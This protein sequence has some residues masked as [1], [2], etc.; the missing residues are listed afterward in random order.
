MTTEAEKLRVADAKETQH[1]TFDD[2]AATHDATIAQP[3]G[4]KA[5]S[6]LVLKRNLARNSN[7]TKAEKTRNFCTEN[8]RQKLRE[9]AHE[10]PAEIDPETVIEYLEER[11]ATSCATLP[12]GGETEEPNKPCPIC[13]GGHFW[14]SKDGGPWHCSRCNPP[15]NDG[16]TTSTLPGARKTANRKWL[17]ILPMIRAAAQSAGLTPEHLWRALSDADIADLEAG[18]ID[19]IALNGFAKAIAEYPYYARPVSNSKPYPVA[20]RRRLDV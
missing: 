20:I 13:T 7:A 8:H 10:L 11:P 16:E 12:V 18:L 17:G 1:A 5:L 4:L 3:T 19:K 15:P 2:S 14:Q 9:D 6:L